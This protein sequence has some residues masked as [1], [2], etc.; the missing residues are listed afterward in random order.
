[1]FVIN[2]GNKKRKHIGLFAVLIFLILIVTITLATKGYLI[3]GD[4]SVTKTAVKTFQQEM[5]NGDNIGKAFT[6]FC[7]EIVAGA[8]LS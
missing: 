4:A 8:Q 5:E 3:P 1:M 2:K 7:K 6:A